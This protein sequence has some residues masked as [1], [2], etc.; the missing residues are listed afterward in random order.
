[1]GLHSRAAT[2]GRPQTRW[3][4]WGVPHPTQLGRAK[5][6]T[7]SL[8]FGAW[9]LLLRL[10]PQSVLGC[11]LMVRESGRMKRTSRSVR[12]KLYR[13]FEAR[14]FLVVK[15]EGINIFVV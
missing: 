2:G 8:T 12:P 6:A 4:R 7:A 11:R 10:Q 1:M 9:N 14:V 15:W 13:R 5:S 3:P